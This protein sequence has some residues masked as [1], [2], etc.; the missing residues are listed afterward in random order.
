[1]FVP[2][3]HFTPLFRFGTN[4]RALSYIQKRCLYCLGIMIMEYSGENC[5]SSPY[6]R[7]P[8][9]EGSLMITVNCESLLL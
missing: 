8:I 1:M 4:P 3:S 9:A 2:F 6:L 5:T 7:S